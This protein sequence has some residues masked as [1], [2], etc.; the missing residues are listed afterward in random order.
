MTFY[1]FFQ[2]ASHALY[3]F[4]TFPVIRVSLEK[5]GKNVRVAKGRFSGINNVQIGNN[6]SLG[7]GFTLLSSRAK[8]YIG[9]DVMFCPGVTVVTGDHRTDILDRPMTTV[10]DN[11]KLPDND[12]DVVFEGDNWIGANAII[13]KGVTVGKGSVVSA[14]AVVTHDVPPYAIVGGVPAKVIKYRFSNDE[15]SEHT[16][17]FEKDDTA[18]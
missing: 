15:V 10:T 16:E 1:D 5:C 3:R 9:D 2:K 12:K 4:L 6:V 13:L 8:I 14:G 18:H 17:L 11:E 7:T